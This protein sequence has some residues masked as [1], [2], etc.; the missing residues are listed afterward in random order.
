MPVLGERIKQLRV[1]R[2]WTQ[3][4]LADRIGTTKHVISTWERGK[5]NPN[6]E[7]IIALANTLEVSADYLLGLTNYPQPHLRDPF[8]QLP[9]SPTNVYTFVNKMGWDLLKLINSGIPLTID[10]EEINTS[11]KEMI[12][13]IIEAAL[14]RKR[15]QE[16]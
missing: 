11:D 16:I 14:K 8:G 1:S 6:P 12:V 15:T 9:I 13:T 3:G 4:E 2:E 7:Q 5:A 10:N